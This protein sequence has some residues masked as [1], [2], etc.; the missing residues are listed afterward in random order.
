MDM[1]R[2]K[3]PEWPEYVAQQDDSTP[4]LKEATN[5]AKKTQNEANAIQ[6]I[7]QEVALRARQN[8]WIDGSLRDHD[9]YGNNV[10][11]E[12]R[13]KYPHYRLAIFYIYCSHEQVFERSRK[14]AEKTGRQVPEKVTRDSI[15]ATEKSVE[16][17][18]EKV[19]YVA[20][21]KNEGPVPQLMSFETMDTS[22]Q[23]TAIHSRFS[24]L[25]E[26]SAE[27]FPKALPSISIQPIYKPAVDPGSPIQALSLSADT[28]GV[29]R[30]TIDTSKWLEVHST[31]SE[32]AKKALL[33]SIA[34]DGT[35]SNLSW[36]LSPEA[37]IN[38]DLESRE[39]AAIPA[40]ATHFAFAP[41]PPTT[42]VTAGCEES[43]ISEIK[44]KTGVKPT[45]AAANFLLGGG[46]LYFELV[47]DNAGTG[48]MCNILGVNAISVLCTGTSQ[49]MLTF[50]PPLNLDASMVEK[51][52]ATKQW[53]AVTMDYLLAGGVTQVAWVPPNVLVSAPYGAFAYKFKTEQQPLLFPVAEIDE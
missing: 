45:D 17:L 2:Q 33:A 12:I 15:I 46:F 28:T 5:A 11:P 7:A 16:I 37:A 14:R 44:H 1:F 30:A 34:K 27:D 20:K 35:A 31:S 3:M 9:W 21:I 4:E 39:L 23:W 6:E 8:T 13:H 51:L 36:S 26:L 38:L 47:E 29:L 50:R 18:S 10:I 42:L 24:R 40:T 49:N 53:S 43:C 52:T 41:P 22:G 25:A 32:T 48:P 19:D